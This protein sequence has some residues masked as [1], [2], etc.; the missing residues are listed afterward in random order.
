MSQPVETMKMLGESTREALQSVRDLT[1]RAAGIESLIAETLAT[2]EIEACRDEIRASNCTAA[3][4][5]CT[6]AALATLHYWI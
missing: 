4:E 3:Y 2:L 1:A 6:S 5:G